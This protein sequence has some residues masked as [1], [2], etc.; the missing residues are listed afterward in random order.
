MYESHPSDA[1]REST[2]AAMAGNLKSPDF[3]VEASLDD[4]YYN[5][6][7]DSEQQVVDD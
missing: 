7:Y 1:F 3:V 6:T 2:Q 5:Q 4:D